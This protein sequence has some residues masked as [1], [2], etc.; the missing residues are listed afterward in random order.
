MP[1]DWELGIRGTR[2]YVA[3][4]SAGAACHDGARCA[5]VKST[6]IGKD[7]FCFL[8]QIVDATAY[9]GKNLAYR[10]AVRT[11]LKPGSVARLLVR[12]HRENGST[13]FRDDMGNHPITARS[14][15]FYEIDAPVIF[16]AR[17]IEFGM[18]VFGEGS[19]WIDKVSVEFSSAPR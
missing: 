8:Y 7:N 10:A 4:T 9:R 11:D 3:E 5:V 12:I 18:Q 13:S 19:A 17:D 1:V 15:T 16:D 14:W 6:G 2:S